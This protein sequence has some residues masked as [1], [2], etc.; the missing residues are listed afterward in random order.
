MRFLKP[1]SRA[2]PRRRASAAGVALVAAVASAG[3]A[4]ADGLSEFLSVHRCRVVA[5]LG[6]IADARIDRDPF[7]IL[8]WPAASPVQGYVQCLFN[9][10]S[11]QIYCEA[12]SGA[13][14]PEIGPPTPEGR[15][16]LA[17]LG[18]DVRKTSSNF[19]RRLPI[20]GDADI[21]AVGELMLSALYLGYRG[22]PDRSIR[23]VSPNASEATAARRCAPLSRLD[24]ASNSG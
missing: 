12:E 13:L 8:A 14:D 3:A 9:D 24:R 2:S 7:L 6:M 23:F 21:A 11:T 17:R 4:S 1:A 10:D 16:A 15:A 22:Q 20:R 19:V 5:T 18:F